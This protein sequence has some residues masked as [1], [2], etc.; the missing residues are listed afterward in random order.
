N[1]AYRGGERGRA[2]WAWLRALEL[3]PRNPAARANL[4]LVNADDKSI[5][6]AAPPLPFS[7]EET[8]LLASACWCLAG[9]AGAWYFLFRRGRRGAFFTA[10]VCALIAASLAGSV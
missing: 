3:Q 7:S 4:D 10:L 1:A 8:L 2:M 6:R 5:D 9:S